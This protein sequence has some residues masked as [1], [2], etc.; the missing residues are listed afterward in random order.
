MNV[1]AAAL[2]V[3]RWFDEALLW[4]SRIGRAG[5]SHLGLA[6]AAPILAGSAYWYWKGPAS[7]MKLL[8]NNH[9]SFLDQKAAL[10]PVLVALLVVF[11]LFHLAYFLYARR[12]GLSLSWTLSRIGAFLTP[13]LGVPFAVA[14]IEPGIEADK[15][16][17]FITLAFCAI[18]GVVAAVSAYRIAPPPRPD[19][20]EGEGLA[21]RARRDRLLRIGGIVLTWVALLAIWMGYGW[22]FTKLAIT[23]HHAMQ[24]RTV[25]LGAYD[26]VFYQS[27]H[28]NLL[29][30][31]FYKGGT[32][33]SAHFDPILAVLSPL[34]RIYPRTEFILG[35]QSFWCGSGVIPVYLIAKRLL[36]SRFQSVLLAACYALHPALHGANMY[37]FHSLTL[38]CVPILWVLYFLQTRRLK[39]YWLTLFVALL[40][41]EDIPLMLAMVGVTTI[42]LP[43]GPR[44]TGL[45]TILVCAAYFVLTKKVFMPPSEDSSNSYSYN[46]YYSDMIPDP[47]SKQGLLGLV[48]TLLTNPTFALRHA[49]AEPKVLYML[50]IFLP[51]AFVPFAARS[52]RLTLLYGLLFTTL[53][54]RAAVFST[55][56]QYSN[57][58]LPFAFAAAPFGILRLKEGGFARAYGLDSSRLQRAI[59]VGAL[60]VSFA[61][62]YKFGGFFE[63]DAFRG[64]FVKVVRKLT[65]EQQT[66]YAWLEETKK[67][68]PPKA[69]VGVTQK[70]GPHV[71]NRKD[72]F[73]Y[74]QKNVQY[75]FVD[76]REIKGDRLKRHRKDVEDGRL[77]QLAKRGS[78]ALYKVGKP[79]PKPK[80][81][82][83]DD[84]DAKPEDPR[85][86]LGDEPQE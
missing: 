65:P 72:V 26:N 75:V 77:E 44:K 55:H 23:N 1:R 37:E 40:V 11:V 78:Y 80:A 60:F 56:F 81:P 18:I 39:L 36:G 6:I 84:E 33:R 86:V 64:G 5:V 47:E 14:L 42:L 79:K 9:V 61:V 48:L 68:I 85:D 69:S 13:L 30:C 63:N 17:P 22:F 50:Q 71:S 28:G 43:D 58:L 52:W 20:T 82:V 46:Y 25:D 51:L 66:H 2:R 31:S 41:R 45:F 73:L 3:A 16:K 19:E 53:A 74:G 59:V 38:S 49:L 76:E 4:V 57:A 54:T 70:M 27:A 67:L 35:L 7:R 21:K 29:G 62:S 32:H 10:R 83:D 8:D 24:T 12:K 15:K 34:Y